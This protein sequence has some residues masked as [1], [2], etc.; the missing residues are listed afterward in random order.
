MNNKI[1]FLLVVGILCLATFLRFSRFP[2]RFGLAY[3]QAQDSLVARGAISLHRI[4]LLGP[5]SSAGPFQTSGIWYWLIIIPTLIYPY[6]VTSPWIFITFLSVG[7]V[8]GMVCLGTY[9]ENRSFGIL[10]GLLTSISTAQVA[11]SV[12]LTNQTPLAFTSFAVLCSAW[13]YMKKKKPNILFFLGFFA[14]LSLSIHLQGVALIAV[15][16]II[17]AYYKLSIRGV[18]F[19]LFGI[20]IA[21]LPVIISEIQHNFMNTTNMIHYIL[22]D[23]Y[24]I[25]LDVFGRRW[26]TFLSVFIPN[27]WSHIVGGL[28]ILVVLLFG[29]AFCDAIR[30]FV[31]KRNPQK[32]VCL[33]SFV[34]MITIV[35]YTRTPLF[36]SF[37]VFLHPF[38]LLF[39]AYSLAFLFKS[40]KVIG[41][42]LFI[43][44]IWNTVLRTK[45]EIMY[46]QNQSDG[47]GRYWRS[48]FTLLFPNQTFSIYDY[49]YES[50]YAS[51]L[52]SLYFSVDNKTDDTGKKIGIMMF[53]P[54]ES[55]PTG[56]LLFQDADYG[57]YDLDA[58]SS[59]Q[60][61][62]IGWV[63]VL[64]EDR[65]RSTQDWMEKN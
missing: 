51:L 5:F 16:L 27:E 31:K 35:R 8:L 58:S 61:G 15:V 55:T 65:L 7:L 12:N 63:R 37:I 29:G 64:P 1:Y 62:S 52:L 24:K 45:Q 46:G 59:S 17:L 49:K 22:Y 43:L 50:S 56:K 13:V 6:A 57:F 28:P 19:L 11:Q 30:T 14:T 40:N 21:L 26:K 2:D 10:L 3:D 39:S 38:I 25:S 42:I 20:I 47:Y 36:S 34:A 33:L 23:Q 60:L 53:P 44:V 32:I 4:P 41:T 18:F 9:L 54:K 48:V